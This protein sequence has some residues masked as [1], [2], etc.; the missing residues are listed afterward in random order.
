MNRIA[1]HVPAA[2]V[3]LCLALAAPAHAQQAADA[4]ED[5]TSEDPAWSSDD[6]GSSEVSGNIDGS[7]A[8]ETDAKPGSLEN[9]AHPDD[10][11]AAA[12]PPAPEEHSTGRRLKHQLKRLLMGVLL[13]VVERRLA[14][15][16]AESDTAS[17]DT[18]PTPQDP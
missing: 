16:S 13:P 12:S 1:K 8:S 7:D 3:L 5:T 10:A 15:A 11:D 17:D 9:A 4:S 14:K 2:A 6:P 18:K